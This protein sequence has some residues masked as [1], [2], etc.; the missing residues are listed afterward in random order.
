[1]MKQAVKL[2][3]TMTLAL[4]V[5]C[6]TSTSKVQKYAAI[7]AVGGGIAGA[8]GGDVIG[9]GLNTVES[10]AVG[11][12]AGGLVGALIGDAQDNRKMSKDVTD[13]LA[14]KDKAAADAQEAARAAQTKLAASTEDLNAANRKIDGLNKQVADLTTELANCKGSRVE[15]TLTADV[16]FNS[17]SADLSS[18]GMK[19]LD[20]AAKQI[21]KDQFVM[22]EGHTDTD[23]IKSSNWKSN[24]ELGAARSLAVLHYLADKGGVDPAKLGASTYSQYQPVGADKAK[25]RRAV[26]VLYTGWPAKKF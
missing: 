7:G 20:A 23:P 11:A 13:A 16:L 21:D 1:M 2:G 22:V 12:L 3:L 19:A 10:G 24:W 18:G 5:G 15:I 17:G 8:W 6:T 25:N 9:H 26:I 14:A 4:A